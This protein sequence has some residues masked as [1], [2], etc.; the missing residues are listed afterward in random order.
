MNPAPLVPAWLRPVLVILLSL[1][2][3]A[4]TGLLSRWLGLS[5]FLSMLI[6]YVSF[7]GAAWLAVH[8][9]WQRRRKTREPWEPSRPIRDD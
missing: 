2:A 5:G 4:A 6:G 8:L 1:T 3:T 7:I 9:G